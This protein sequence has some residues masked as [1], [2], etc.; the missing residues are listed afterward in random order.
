MAGEPDPFLHDGEALGQALRERLSRYP[1]SPALRAAVRRTLAPPTPAW[2]PR[3]LAPAGAALATALAMVLW[4]A[5]GLPTTT[6]GE[7]VHRMV[8]AAVTEHARGIAWGQRQPDWVPAVL[9]RAMEES[10]I[11]LNW[12]FTGD[13][14]IVLVD[15]RPTYVEGHRGLTL[16]YLDRNGHTVSYIV[17]PAA[18]L[19]L[20]ERGRVQIDRWRPL[21]RREN[22]WSLIVWK[23]AGLLCLLVAD[24]VSEQDLTRLKS[25]FVKVRSATELYAVY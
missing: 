15:A 16:S 2:Q 17:I 10:G 9:P 11:V 5:P 12:V 23:Q 24:L 25:Y 19:A 14:E 1:A 7:A 6:P 3:W 4:L 18:T 13:D 20:P 8:R 22:G 21:L